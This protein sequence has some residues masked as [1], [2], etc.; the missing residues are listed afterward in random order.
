MTL[1]AFRVI[2]HGIFSRLYFLLL[3]LDIHFFFKIMGQRWGGFVS[4]YPA[5]RFAHTGL[6]QVVPS[7]LLFSSLYFSRIFP[8]TA[9][10]HERSEVYFNCI[11]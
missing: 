11:S 8:A 5:F 2:T 10:R 6:V 9:G 4:F 1:V 7:A 3:G